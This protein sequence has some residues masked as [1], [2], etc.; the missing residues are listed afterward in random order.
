MADT[1]PYEQYRE[2]ATPQN[3]MDEVH[4]G[5]RVMLQYEKD[6]EAAELEL[7]L[8]NAKLFKMKHEELPVLMQKLGKLTEFDM[9]MPDGSTYHVKREE[10]VSAKLSEGDA[11]KVFEWM[12]E[13]EYD[14]HISNDIVIPFTKGQQDDMEKVEA[15]LKL[16]PNA[17]FSRHQNI[18]PSTY[19][20]F[21]KRLKEQGVAVDEKVFGIHVVKQVTAKLNTKTK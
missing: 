1:D 8:R 18:H 9:E 20:A 16:L 7:K 21:C 4:Q 10:K 13:N 12:T 17:Q 15:H 2:Q 6:V 19:T 3:I 11:K 5:V 14:H